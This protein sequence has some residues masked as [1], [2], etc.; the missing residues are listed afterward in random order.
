MGIGHAT[1]NCR[2]D[3]PDMAGRLTA[4]SIACRSDT[5]GEVLMPGVQ[6]GQKKDPQDHSRVLQSLQSS[7]LPHEHHLADDRPAIDLQVVEVYA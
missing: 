3:W 6:F 1:E 5:S 7:L 4:P 2:D